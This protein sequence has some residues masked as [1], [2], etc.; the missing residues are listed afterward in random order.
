MTPCAPTELIYI[1]AGEHVLVSAGR[2]P[3]AAKMAT[4]VTGEAMNE[5]RQIKQLFSDIIEG[6]PVDGCKGPERDG[7]YSDDHLTYDTNHLIAAHGWVVL[8]VGQETTRDGDGNPWH[9]TTIVLGEPA[10]D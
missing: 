9:R 3:L 6:C 4:K 10:P 7:F 2:A 8:H 1:F 5:V